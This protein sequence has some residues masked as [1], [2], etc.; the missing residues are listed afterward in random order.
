M[1]TTLDEPVKQVYSMGFIYLE[2][3]CMEEIRYTHHLFFK[4]VAYNSINVRNLSV[5]L[6]VCSIYRR[7]HTQRMTCG[8]VTV[9]D[10]PLSEVDIP[11][12]V[13]CVNDCINVLK[14]AIL[15]S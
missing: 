5:R 4:M 7:G 15:K 13:V 6:L 8:K 2:K 3:K 12:S 11:H 1:A 14:R 10:H 9:I